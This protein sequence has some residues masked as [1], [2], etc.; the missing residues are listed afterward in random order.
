MNERFKRKQK[1]SKTSSYIRIIFN[2]FLSL[3]LCCSC[4]IHFAVPVN[5][6]I[7][8]TYLWSQTS[9]RN[10][11]NVHRIIYNDPDC[12]QLAIKNNSNYLCYIFV[13]PEF[14]SEEDRDTWKSNASVIDNVISNGA[15]VS[16]YS[17]IS[18]SYTDYIVTDISGN[19][20]RKYLLYAMF[21]VD[22]WIFNKIGNNFPYLWKTKSS[23]Y[24]K[25]TSMSVTN[26]I[27]FVKHG[28]Y[29]SSSNWIIPDYGF[30]EYNTKYSYPFIFGSANTAG[31]QRTFDDTATTSKTINLH[32]IDV[33][34]TYTVNREV[35]TVTE[36]TENYVLNQAVDINNQPITE[37]NLNYQ[38]F[39]YNS[40]YEVTNVNNYYGEPDENNDNNSENQGGSTGSGGI[41]LTDSLKQQQQ[42]QQTIESGAVVNNNENSIASG[43]ATANITVEKEAVIINTGGS[44]LTEEQIDRINDILNGEDSN[45]VSFSEAVAA[46]DGFANV[47][48]KF[49]SVGNEFMS[50]FPAWSRALL[51]IS[52]GLTGLMIALRLLHIFK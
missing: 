25:I 6:E 12:I 28:A 13:S 20:V 41:T 5:A 42:Q 44:D 27:F 21:D 40:D 1:T 14:D 17:K 15:S 36:N 39:T 49:A 3:V 23:S 52:L 33:W 30:G 8:S 22:T 29:S 50:F 2:V 45:K 10:G 19:K 34:N 46:I 48:K 32:P 51:G 38:D 47:G 16:G 24:G 11:T 37:N 43:A 7:L 4:F 31:D 26:A 9:W 35:S 18:W